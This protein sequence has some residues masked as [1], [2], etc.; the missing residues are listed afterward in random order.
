MIEGV[1]GVPVEILVRM[2]GLTV[3]CSFHC[4]FVHQAHTH[5]QEGNAVVLLNL[6]GKLY[7]WVA[8][9]EVLSEF[10]DCILN[11]SWNPLKCLEEKCVKKK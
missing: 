2:G 6:P 10:L 1:V 4:A 5:I 11:T 7:V 8:G 9:V 3:D